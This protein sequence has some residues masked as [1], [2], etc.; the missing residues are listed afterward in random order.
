ME[1]DHH[2][3][4]AKMNYEETILAAIAKNAMRGGGIVT[5]STESER[6]NQIRRRIRPGERSVLVSTRKT[7]KPTSASLRDIAGKG[8]RFVMRADKVLHIWNS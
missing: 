8:S 7:E 1:I 2:M 5:A 6:M 4:A 3:I